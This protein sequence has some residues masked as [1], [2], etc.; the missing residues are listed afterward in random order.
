MAKVLARSNTVNFAFTFKDE[1]GDAATVASATVQIVYPGRD[2]RET[3]KLTL[4]DNSGSWEVTWD[5]SKSRGGWIEFH[6]HALTSGSPA[7][8]YTE[9]GRF[10]LSSNE[11]NLQHDALP[12]GTSSFKD[13]SG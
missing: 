4:V 8:S 11:A 9:D 1:D 7:T 13:Y 5:S 6:A 2:R 3:E 10:K 12:Q